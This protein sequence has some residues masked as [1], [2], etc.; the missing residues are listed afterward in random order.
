MSRVTTQGVVRHGLQLT[1]IRT[2]GHT[3]G[4]ARRRLITLLLLPV[5]FIVVFVSGSKKGPNNHRGGL[6]L[7]FLCIRETATVLDPEGVCGVVVGF[8]RR[9]WDHQHNLTAGE[10]KRQKG[11]ICFSYYCKYCCCSGR[12]AFH[13]LLHVFLCLSLRTSLSRYCCAVVAD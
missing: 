5:K 3:H 11:N 4:G 12:H 7:P 10:S 1:S 6:R 2:S 13:F 8:E 9:V